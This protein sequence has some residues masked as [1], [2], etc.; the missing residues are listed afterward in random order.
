M[1][2]A[3]TRAVTDGDRRLAMRNLSS[4]DDLGVADDERICL[5]V[6]VSQVADP[7]VERK[8]YDWT[9]WLSLKEKSRL[10]SLSSDEEREGGAKLTNSI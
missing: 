10:E 2:D 6:V 1:N 4:V 8:V 3:L 9:D 5:D 7:I